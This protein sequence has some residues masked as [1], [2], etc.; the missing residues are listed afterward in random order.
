MTV[1]LRKGKVTIGRSSFDVLKL[2]P[3][4]D[5]PVVDTALTGKA[6]ATLVGP[7]AAKGFGDGA[8]VQFILDGRFCYRTL[9]ESEV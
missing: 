5:M 6:T 2:D 7:N 9:R 8:Q 1:N 3:E 4:T